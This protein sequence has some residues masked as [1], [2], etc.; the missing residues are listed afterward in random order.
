[1]FKKAIVT[2]SEGF[3][4]GHLT[5]RLLEM[6]IEVVGIDDMSSGLHETYRQH[7][8][9]KN[10]IGKQISITDPKV[11]D[12]FRNFRP[13]VVFHLAAKSGV[14]PSVLNPTFSDFTNINGSVNLLEAS[15]EF[16]VKRFIFSSSS[17]VYGGVSEFPTD[18]LAQTNPK[19]PYALQKFLGL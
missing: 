17:S 16:G 2:G 1:M 7:L 12:I 19:S 3:I 18:E 10:Y 9:S 14:S 5:D 4:G 13:D 8:K 15:R 11:Q 6:G